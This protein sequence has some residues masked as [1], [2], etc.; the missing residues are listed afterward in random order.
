MTQWASGRTRLALGGFGRSPALAMDGTE[1]QGA[2]T[3]ARN[4]CHESGDEFGSAQYRMES[5]AV[6]ARRCLA[7]LTSA[8]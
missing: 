5:A 6:L 7:A 2:E 4:A 3:A 1:A 8:G